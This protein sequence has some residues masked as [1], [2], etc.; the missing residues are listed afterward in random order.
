MAKIPTPVE[1][2]T[3]E[4]ALGELEEILSALEKETHDLQSTMQQFE[5]GRALLSRC[6]KLLEEAELKVSQL[7]ADGEMSNWE[8]QD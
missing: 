8:G 4:A 7:N 5:R 1:S 2:L 3:Y 6:Q